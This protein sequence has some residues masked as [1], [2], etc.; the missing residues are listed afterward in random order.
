MRKTNRQWRL[1]RHPDGLP[2]PDIW[3]LSEGPVPE[4]GPSE[5]LVQAR[6][7]DISPYMRG[8]INPVKSHY[9]TGVKPGDVMIGGAIGDVVC[10]NA[11]EFSPG[12]MVVSDF[13]FGWQ[14]YAVLGPNKLRRVDIG[15]APAECWLDALGVNGVTAYL[16][17]FD[18]ASMRPG[19]TV[20][21]SAAAGSVGQ[22][23]GQLAKIAGGRAIA[24]TS[25]SEKVAWC[26]ELGFDAGVAY[27]ETDD[28]IRSVAEACPRGVDVY[29]DNTAGEILDA[30]L[31]N[32]AVGARLTLCGTVSLSGK[33]GQPDL[34][35]RFWRQIVIARAR[36]QGF[37]VLD[38]PQQRYTEAQRRLGKWVRDGHIRQRFDV[39]EG[40]EAAPAALIRVLSSQNIGKQLVAL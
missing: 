34:G 28:L 13:E 17:L 19:D 5:I 24:V 38:Y 27:R 31:Q 1:A 12:D 11:D 25:T 21:I 32:L 22:I 33:F 15:L 16:G 23:A 10:S 30:V 20:V 2:T 18:A 3:T 8:K 4:P 7:L 37:L 29:I 35:E 39:A 26:R 6:Y 36:L 40:L 9:G 14:D